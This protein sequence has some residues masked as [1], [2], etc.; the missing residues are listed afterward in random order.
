MNRADPVSMRKALRLT[1]E[2]RLQGILFVPMPVLDKEDHAKLQAD[3]LERLEKM[4]DTWQC[5]EC[6]TGVEIPKDERC[7]ECGREYAP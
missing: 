1:D 4:I 3:C 7:P 5:P 6:C 2:M